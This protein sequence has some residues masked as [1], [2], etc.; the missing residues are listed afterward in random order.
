MM[1]FHFFYFCF[2]SKPYSVGIRT[3]NLAYQS[4]AEQAQ[5]TFATFGGLAIVVL[6]A[7]R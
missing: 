5:K 4:Q 1:F 2:L 6:L 7:G 3:K